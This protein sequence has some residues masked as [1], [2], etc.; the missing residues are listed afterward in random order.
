MPDRGTLVGREAE[1][2]RLCE[3]LDRARRGSGR[4][5]LVSGDAGIGK[6]RLIAELAEREADALVLSGAAVQTGTA[7]YGAVVAALRPRLRAEPDALDG[8][9]PAGA[10][11][12]RAPAGARHAGRHLGPRDARRGHPLRARTA[13]RRPPGAA[14]PRRPALVRRGDARAAVGA[15]RAAAASCRCSCSPGYRSDGLPRDHGVRRLRTSCGARARWTSWRSARSDRDDV[16]SRPEHCARGAA[17]AVAGRRRSTT[18]T[19]GIAVLRRGAGGRA[20][21]RAPR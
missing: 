18:A 14:R 3:A 2:A 19:Q 4:I 12:R 21:R 5:V 15:G 9:R 20:A 1:L 17:G 6:T 13:G 11:P 10:A 8:V 7:P 16:A